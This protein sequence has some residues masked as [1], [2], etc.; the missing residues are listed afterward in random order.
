MFALLCLSQPTTKEYDV[1]TELHIPVP[2][3]DH[4]VVVPDLSQFLTDGWTTDAINA[5]T[6][7]HIPPY[8]SHVL[9][10]APTLSED[11]LF[12][13][14]FQDAWTDWSHGRA[15]SHFVRSVGE[16]GASRKRFEYLRGTSPNSTGIRIITK[17]FFDFV[18]DASWLTDPW[19]V[20]MSAEMEIDPSLRQ[21][22]L[23]YLAT[24]AVHYGSA[25]SNPQ[26][27]SIR[28]LVV[29]EIKGGKLS[30]GALSTR[31]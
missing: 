18:E 10:G 30:I 17:E 12:G 21:A 28:D 15:E 31:S 29:R 20:L 25:A 14:D 4:L 8:G 22:L 7:L 13:N 24:G 6:G 9:I 23:G 26:K 19:G 3:A 16:L 1:T 2:K 11:E 27:Y 5:A